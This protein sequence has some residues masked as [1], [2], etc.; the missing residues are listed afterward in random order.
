MTLFTL[1]IGPTERGLERRPG[2]PTRVL[3][4][5]R[6]RQAW[7]ARYERVDVRER[8]TLLAPQDL[9]SADGISLRATAAIR[10]TVADPVA[11]S[12]TH[13]DPFAVVYLADVDAFVAG[14]PRPAVPVRPEHPGG[15][16]GSTLQPALGRTDREGEQGH[17][18]YL[19]RVSS[20]GLPVSCLS[21]GCAVERRTTARAGTGTRSSC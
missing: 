4:P 12:E 8:S 11:F 3:D 5:G 10:W 17:D 2:Y 19:L 9:L 6:H 16:A 14:P 15:V 21:C 1:T 18:G 13:E 7:R 20:P